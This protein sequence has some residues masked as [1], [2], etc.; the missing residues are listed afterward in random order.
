MP[1]GSANPNMFGP[2]PSAGAVRATPSTPATSAQTKTNAVGLLRVAL[3]N[4][5]HVVVVVAIKDRLLGRC[6]A[7]CRLK[8]DDRGVSG[9]GYCGSRRCVSWSIDRDCVRLVAALDRERRV[10]DRRVH[11]RHVDCSLAG[12]FVA[13]VFRSEYATG[14]SRDDRALRFDTPGDYRFRRQRIVRRR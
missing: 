13:I 6:R 8:A 7:E 14:S 5:F 3:G 9:G 12:K 1:V 4:R 10:I 11:N 2:L